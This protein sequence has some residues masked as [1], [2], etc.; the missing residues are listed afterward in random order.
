MVDSIHRAVSLLEKITDAW[1]GAIEFVYQSD[2]QLAQALCDGRARRVRYAAPD[3]IPKEVFAGAA[4]PGVHIA[5]APVLGHGRIERLW[6]LLEQ[7]LS[8]SY[9]RYGNLGEH[10]GEGRAPVL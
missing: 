2:A 8:D 9:H 4:K 5:G 1:G 7:S 3:R 6:Y 10:G